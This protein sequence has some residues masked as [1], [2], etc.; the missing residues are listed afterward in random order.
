MIPWSRDWSPSALT[1]GYRYLNASSRCIIK[2]V[3]AS[4]TQ[5]HSSI[6]SYDF[7]HTL[8]P[9]GKPNEGMDESTPPSP[10]LWV[11]P[12]PGHLSFTGQWEWQWPLDASGR[13]SMLLLPLLLVQAGAWGF[14]TG[15]L[16]LQELRRAF[17]AS[18]HLARKLLSEVQ[19]YV[20]S[21]AE[22]RLPGCTWT[23]LPLGHHLPNAFPDLQAWRHLS[24]SEGQG[25]GKLA[26]RPGTQ[27]KGF[28][29]E[30]EGAVWAMRLDLRD[31][32]YRHFRFQVLAAGFNC[33]EEEEDKEE[34]EEG[35]E[36]LLGALDGPKQVSFQVSW[37][38]LLYTYQLLHSLE[39]VLSR[40]VRDLLLLTMP[41]D[42]GPAW[43][44]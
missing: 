32:V 36:L 44:S 30:T 3:P 29:S 23:L 20:H 18:L 24:V 11:I 7:P 13:L 14:P 9:S 35:K 15:P 38:Q 4:P 6:W 25:V 37:P 28:N 40:A 22:S 19:S 27:D 43:D 1:L 33:S 21:F 31:R 10:L 2:L 26:V 12:L 16:S 42:P 34:E 39:L 5:T 17:T 8:Q 41:Q